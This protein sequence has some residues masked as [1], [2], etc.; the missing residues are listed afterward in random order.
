M[1]GAMGLTAM[2]IV[3]SPLGARSGAHM[4]PALTLTFFR[5]G[6]I[7]AGDATGYLAAQFTGGIIGILIA[8]GLFGGLPADPSVNYVATLPGAMGP[9]VAFLAELAMSF[10]LMSVV[11]QVSNTPRIARLTGLCAGVLVAAYIVIEA[12]LSGMS[13]NPARTLGSNLLAHTTS[14]LWVYFTAPPFG[15]LLAAEAYVRVH[16]HAGVR[17]AKLD[18]PDTGHCIFGCKEIKV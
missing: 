16:G 4:N 17:C 9:A 14:T 2:A 13:M 15:M 3:Y 18:R 10:C 7:T 12:P 11:L 6:K 8:L 5:L 1:G